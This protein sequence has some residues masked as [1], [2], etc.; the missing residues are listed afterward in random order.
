MSI[1]LI[2]P[3]YQNG[4]APRDGLPANPN[5]RQGLVGLW[6]TELGISGLTL[7]DQSG[8]STP[9]GVLTNMDGSNWAVGRYGYALSYDGVSEYVN[10]GTAPPHLQTAAFSMTQVIQPDNAHNLMQLFSWTGGTLCSG[11]FGGVLGSTG[12][13][14]LFTN[15][16]N[17]RNWPAAATTLLVNGDWHVVTFTIPGNVQ[18]DINSAELWIDGQ[19]IAVDST[20]ATGATTART[21]SINIGRR[22]ANM[23]EYKGNIGLTALHNRVL[24]DG[25]IVDW[26]GDPLAI[27]RLEDE[28]FAPPVGG[29]YP[30]ILQAG[31][32][33]GAL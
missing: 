3:S 25:E 11:W 32:Y 1:G 14:V 4:F 17:R 33:I 20:D 29:T 24:A 31:Q 8:F 16:N 12:R 15:T 10:L 5:L 22:I 9:D 23:Q 27:L 18:A 2:N 13:P 30:G 28:P 21:G 7:F 6:S 19:K 26:H